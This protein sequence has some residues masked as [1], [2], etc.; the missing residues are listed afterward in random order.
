M[1]VGVLTFHRCINYGSY[2]QARCLVEGLKAMGHDAELLDHDSVQVRSAEWRCAFNPQ[3]PVRTRRDD[4]AR[5]G[6][7]AR[8][9][10]T[11]F[12]RL[13]QS[14]RFSLDHPEEAGEYDAVVVGSDEVWNFRHP[15]Y[16]HKPI[17]FGDRLRARR[18]ISYAASFGNHD[19]AQGIDP[20]WAARLDRFD[21]LSV[22]DENS[23]EIVRHSVGVKP[24]LV[25][26]P[27]L[28]FP[29]P[30][31]MSL[32][33]ERPYVAVYGHSFPAWLAYRVRAWAQATG[34]RVVSIGY[35]N[36]WADEQRIESGPEAFSALIAGADAVATNFFHGCV[37]AL[38]HQRPFVCAPS[39]YRFNKVR[40]LLRSLSAERH[41]VGSEVP[42]P[43][44]DALLGDP[45]DPAIGDRIAAMRIISGAYLGAAL[46]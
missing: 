37:F 28:Q 18:L 20:V 31:I 22:R 44:Y 24:E 9:F 30:R 41:L 8:R 14:R 25:L 40:D 33:E 35:R 17:F 16:G 4:L 3:L 2:W 29:P 43:T 6:A 15:W 39:P 10:L 38:H 32:G 45:L 21:W 19:A 5:Y 12:D 26:D 42:P 13:P 23:R 34:R 11:A 1:N 27:C 46:A 36:D 7:K